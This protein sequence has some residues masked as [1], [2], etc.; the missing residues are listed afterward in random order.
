MELLRAFGDGENGLLEMRLSGTHEKPLHTPGIVASTG[1]I[2]PSGKHAKWPMCFILEVRDKKAAGLTLYFDLL[3]FL[4]GIG[5]IPEGSPM[6][7][8]PS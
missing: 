6:G 1:L 7:A 8:R 5:A 3:T 2:P 4:R